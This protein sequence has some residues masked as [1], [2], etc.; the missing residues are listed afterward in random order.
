M[1]LLPCAWQHRRLFIRQFPEET[2]VRSNR[3]IISRVFQTEKWRSPSP[4]PGA[5]G[6]AHLVQPR[7]IGSSPQSMQPELSP[8]RQAW[9]YR[10]VA[11]DAGTC[12]FGQR[13]A[14]EIV[15]RDTDR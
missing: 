14:Q 8:G 3:G 1:F 9:Y 12:A 11:A 5:G 13:S 7:V 4:W 6:S 10:N 2:A 15:T